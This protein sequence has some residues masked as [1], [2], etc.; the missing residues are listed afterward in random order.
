MRLLCQLCQQGLL[1]RAVAAVVALA[2]ASA[3]LAGPGTG[4]LDDVT[5]R[6]QEKSKEG[7][8]P[9]ADVAGEKFEPFTSDVMRGGEPARQVK[10]RVAGVTDLWLIAVGVPTSGKGY[11]DWGD[12]KLID[13]NGKVTYLSDLTP[14][15]DHRNY[16]G[17]FRD[18]RQHGKGPIR[19]GERT[20]KRGIG[21]HADCEICY[22]LDGR[23]EWFEAWI[24]IDAET[25]KRGHVQFTVSD[26]PRGINAGKPAKTAKSTKPAEAARPAPVEIAA[27]LRRAVEDLTASF[28]RRYPNGKTYLQRL[29]AIDEALAGKPG[30]ERLAEIGKQI[31]A[32]R[33][34]A[35]LANPLLDFEKLLVVKRRPL[36]K[37]GKPGDP[38]R[39]R[40]WTIGFPRSSHGKSSLPKNSSGFESEIAVLSPVG[41]TGKLTALYRPGDPKFIGDVD[42]HFD[43]DRML[44]TMPDAGG[45][46]QVHEILADGAG[47][48]QVT[49]GD[50]PDVHNDDACYLPDGDIIFASTACF[51]GV[52]CNR[53]QV[54]LLYRMGPDGGNVR[55]L[56][57]D[58]DHNYH[59]SV[60]PDGRVMY[61]RWEYSDLPHAYSRI[62]FH[63]NP[64]G[65]GQM[66][67]YGGSSYWPNSTFWAR[68]IPGDSTK[69]VGVVAGHHQSYRAGELVLFDV[70]RGRNEADGA[71]QRIPGYGKPVEPIVMDT[72]TEKSWPKF[73]HPWPLCDP[74]TGLGA[75]KYFLVTAKLD[76]RSPWDIYLVDVFDNMVQLCHADGWALFEPIP[77]RPRP[78]P[79]IVADRTD[80]SRKEALVYLADIYQGGGLA[81]VPRGEIK[82]L[83]LMTYHFC[84]QGLGGQY[85]RVGLDGPWDVRQV[86]GT[87]PVEPD[88]SAAFRIP[89]NT[90]IAVQPL[91]GEGKAVQLMRSWFVGMPGEVVSCVGCHERPNTPSVPRQT[92]APGRAPSRIAPYAD[93]LTGFSFQRE[94]QP[95]LDRYCIGCHNGEKRDDGKAVPDLR[96]AAPAK[97]AVGKGKFPPAYMALRRLVRTP[98][99]EPDLHML[100]V[101]DVHADTTQLV[102][103]LRK[104]HHGVKLGPQAWERL[105]TWIDVQAPAHGTWREIAGDPAVLAQRDRRQAC[106]KQYVGIDVDPEAVPDA[107]PLADEPAGRAE[108]SETRDAKVKG[109]STSARGERPT[110][111][112]A[113]QPSLKGE[114]PAQT[115]E[116]GEGVKM[117]LVQVPGGRF[118]MG[119]AD[120]LADERPATTV[121]IAKPF[122]IGRT[123][124]TNRQYAAFDPT[125]D[126]RLEYGDGLH[127]NAPAR[128]SPLNGP[129]QP[130]CRV[131]WNDAARFCRWLSRKTGRRFSLPTESQWEYACRADT[132]TPM[133]YGRCD[134]DFAQLANLADAKLLR[135]GTSYGDF[136][137]KVVPRWR[138]AVQSVNDEHRVSAPVGSFR[139]NAWGLYDMHGNVAEW[140]RSLCEP[141]PYRDDDGRNDENAQGRRVV[142]GGSW[143]DLPARAR[144]AF[145][146]SYKPWLGVYNVGFRVVCEDTGPS[147]SGPV[148]RAETAKEMVEASG[149]Q[150]GL[151]VHLGCGDGRDTLAMRV[152]PSFLVHGLDASR[153]SIEKARNN[154]GKAGL[155][156]SIL[157]DQLLGDVLPYTDNLVNVLVVEETAIAQ[158]GVSKEE[159]LRVLAPRGVAL[160]R[161]RAGWKKITKPW[162][163][164][165]DEWRHF[166]H[167]PDNNAVADDTVSGI[168]HG[169]QW[170]AGPRYTRQHGSHPSLM[171]M[172]SAGGRLF[173]IVDEAPISLMDYPPRWFLVARDAFNGRLLWKKKIEHWLPEGRSFKSMSF[174]FQYRIAATAERLF[175]TMGLSAP[176]SEIDPRTGRVLREYEGTGH[177]A[178]FF[179]AGSTL[180]VVTAD[181]GSEAESYGAVAAS[182][183][184]SFEYDKKILAFD[185][186]TGKC[187]WKKE[188][189]DLKSMALSGI[190]IADN[191][192]YFLFDKKLTAFDLPTGN[193]VWNVEHG[194][195]VRSRYTRVAPIIIASPPNGLLVLFTGTD[196]R[197]FSLDDGRKIWNVAGKGG[198]GAKFY[199]EC[200]GS[201]MFIVGERIWFGAYPPVVL[202]V[203][204]GKELAILPQS[205]QP[206]G[207]H[208]RCYPSKATVRYLMTAKRGV[209]FYDMTGKDEHEAAPWARGTCNYGLLPANG[210][211]Y[212]PPSS[213]AC[214]IDAKL[215]D[216]NALAPYNEA[217]IATKPENVFVKGP[218][219]GRTPTAPG[220][221][222]ADWPMFRQGPERKGFL[223]ESVSHGLKPLWRTPVLD[224]K[225]TPPVIAGEAVVFV[226]EDT[227]V[228]HAVDRRT[229]QE[230]W[231]FQ[232]HSRVVTAPALHGGWVLFGARNGWVYCLDGASGELA[233]RLRVAPREFQTVSY[234]KLESLWPAFGS[235]LVW[236]D[237][238]FASAGRSSY[239]NGGLFLYAIDIPSGKIEHSHR[240][241]T[242]RDNATHLAFSTAGTINDI[243]KSDGRNVLITRFGFTPD[244]K[245][246]ENTGQ[247]VYSGAGLYDD[248]WFNRGFWSYGHSIEKANRENIQDYRAAMKGPGGYVIA[249]DHDSVYGIETRV[250]TNGGGF[251]IGEAYMTVLIAEKVGE[252]VFGTKEVFDYQPGERH[253]F[254]RKLTW[255]I[256]IPFQS[257][258]LA[259]SKEKLFVAGWN[260][261]PIEDS[262]VATKTLSASKGKSRAQD[263]ATGKGSGGLAVFRLHKTGDGS[264]W[265]CSKKDGSVL[266]R[267]SLPSGAI[268]DGVAIAQGCLFIAME[269]G[270]V[271][272]YG[273][274]FPR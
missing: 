98:T 63:M 104:G 83:R 239:L 19:I 247:H 167:G 144:S 169:V 184:F 90:P 151:I 226:E 242:P 106:L 259:A 67:L 136:C 26:K 102:Q 80:L 69:F 140:T 78:R 34:E 267:Y 33:R 70:A 139:P 165:I 110:P 170:V 35:L 107:R 211:L 147:P 3:T 188:G 94:I 250:P 49:R 64:D 197:A 30:A 263:R 191:R 220:N 161:M 96:L 157:V 213:C 5:L 115:V 86:L 134:A 52:P 72:L 109:T 178:K 243:M 209:E 6:R 232:T 150:G 176:V 44:L 47:L 95:V 272:C 252:T 105:I 71:V 17:V 46:F 179:V 265:V 87:V 221:S 199:Y 141:Y 204:T 133:A 251:K 8:A 205:V 154:I 85:D 42:L 113:R 175:V 210:L 23:Y 249:V 108:Q 79:P 269:D 187:L 100:A 97:T 153:E 215:A 180:L 84:Y 53:S 189:A 99:Q 166:R 116:L 240:M 82:K 238:L 91:D 190:S 163:D 156:E 66:A 254:T 137:A 186:P 101:G 260:E 245:P 88:G 48:R 246:T 59:P 15:A 171:G 229:G 230:R 198:K 31:D 62:M 152:T 217:M 241:D 158:L 206:S 225:I 55:Q 142:R 162:P 248:R 81:G 196:V 148:A 172:V 119:D 74:S 159:M 7:P 29:D 168:P 9:A 138:P 21:T 223:N 182:R 212:A 24:G 128:G 27:A 201:A 123:E 75:G 4:S 10:L 271:M 2:A 181:Y 32:L 194:L 117:E 92:L 13:A 130:V 192:A 124:V 65:T 61:L 227:G 273:K 270:S 214:Y 244:L 135:I 50:Q 14:A 132:T 118:V 122:W 207:H 57:F 12:A 173:Y 76:S 255:K 40:G 38:D 125:H 266:A 218:A 174:L 41:P 185:I 195:D 200:S 45:R 208:A 257:R 56:C 256:D 228:V 155:A 89:A 264:F 126:S 236:N 164:T 234:E 121:T 37:D 112:A 36:T 160:V 261:E 237:T 68:S 93:A 233:W 143:Y 203:K 43:A 262:E 39:A 54:C 216:L 202:D 183:E 231:T 120:G 58:Q 127:F 25:G 77:F 111:G 28:G 149:F 114:P 219:Y 20:F 177:A 73:V 146:L 145:R 258:G 11:S 222:T 224:K 131:S 193:P 268:F 253:Q 1:Q 235:V 274:R 22:R 103:M 51:Q 60:M 18:K 16:G 129:D